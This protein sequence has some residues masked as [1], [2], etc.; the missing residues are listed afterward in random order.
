[1]EKSDL[2]IIARPRRL[3]TRTER[4]FPHSHSDC[5][6]AV[7]S[8]KTSPTPTK[9]QERLTESRAETISSIACAGTGGLIQTA[10]GWGRGFGQ[11]CAP[12]Q[13]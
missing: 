6:Y 9:S 12:E 8:F 13:K 2:R 1:M 3:E 11:V 10:V 4:A 7:P 5:G